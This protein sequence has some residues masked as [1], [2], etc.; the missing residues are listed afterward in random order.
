[1]A[2]D[3]KKDMTVSSLGFFFSF[4]LFFPGE[5]VI[6]KSNRCKQT[7]KEV[8]RKSHFSL[9][10]GKGKEQRSERENI[11]TTTTP[12][13]P[14][15]PEGE[16]WFFTSTWPPTIRLRGV[17]VHLASTDTTPM[18]VEK[19]VPPLPMPSAKVEWGL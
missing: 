3:L 17:A 6:Y 9:T 14:T 1:M 4:F 16:G 8:P 5:I 18:V 12:T 15:C 2:Q 11:W 7:N 19:C 10:K 13:K